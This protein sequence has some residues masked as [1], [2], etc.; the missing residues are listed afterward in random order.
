MEETINKDTQTVGREGGTRALI[1]LNPG[2]LQR[3]YMTVEFSEMFL[4]QMREM[5]GYA[6]GNND[7]T[8]LQKSR[9][10]KDEKDIQEMP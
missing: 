2:V 7:H 1:S 8:D 9:I 3:Y 5:A 6:Q 4:R 10:K